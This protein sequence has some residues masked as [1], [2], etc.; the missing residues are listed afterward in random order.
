MSTR[1]ALSI[2]ECRCLSTTCSSRAST[3]AASADPP[4]LT[5]SFATASTGARRRPVRK[6][7]P[8]Q[9]QRRGRQHR[10]P[11]RRLR[12][13][14]QLCPSASSL[15]PF[16][17]RVVTHWLRHRGR[18]GRTADPFRARSVSVLLMKLEPMTEQLLSR[19]RG[20]DELAFRE[21]TDS[22]SAT[23]AAAAAQRARAARRTRLLGRRKRNDPGNHRSV[24]QRGA[25]TRA[26]STRP[27]T[28][29]SRACA[30]PR[31]AAGTRARRP[32]RGRVRARRHERRGRAAH[33]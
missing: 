18:P 24:R 14:L 22:R 27:A 23:A 33:R 1:P 19:A 4:A 6:R 15:V 16:C 2:T 7:P 29:R 30:T 31:L 13:S 20:G 8:P 10:R 17:A 26:R 9:T 28:D 3:S 21:L 5:M 11:R 32:V 12:R 25:P